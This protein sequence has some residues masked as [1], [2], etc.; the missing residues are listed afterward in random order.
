M[1]P[2]AP[3]GMGSSAG[4]GSKATCSEDLP[5]RT[6]VHDPRARVQRP[7]RDATTCRRPRRV[8]AAGAP[9]LGED[10]QGDLPQGSR[11]PRLGRRRRRHHGRRG[12]GFRNVLGVRLRLRP[13]QARRPVPERLPG[14]GR[15]GRHPVQRDAHRGCRRPHRAA[16]WNRGRGRDGDRRGAGAPDPE[17]S[18]RY[19]TKELTRRPTPSSAVVRL[20]LS[21]SRRG[22]QATGLV[23]VARLWQRT[24][25]RTAGSAR[26]TAYVEQSRCSK[27]ILA[28]QPTISHPAC[29][30]SVVRG[31][32]VNSIRSHRRAAFALPLLATVSLAGAT[33]I[34]PSAAL[35]G[36]D[37]SD[38]SSHKV[39]VC[40][41]VG[42]PGVN[43]RLQ[44]GNNPI[45][46][47]LHSINEFKT[48]DGDIET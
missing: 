41:Y 47:D 20:R 15:R 3:D 45:S 46:V 34:L 44:T 40:K 36:S 2:D 39:F 27:P 33:L 19:G 37:G 25:F 23:G 11:G 26:W 31:V 1:V 38:L 13:Q 18:G 24:P 35:A 42:T 8:P 17:L 10:R 7:A 21:G 6:A 12:P 29:I 22:S 43:E 28:G 9:G 16:P 32:L 4:Y 48:F 5:G 14:L 30:D